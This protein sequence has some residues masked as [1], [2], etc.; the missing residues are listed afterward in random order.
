[1]TSRL[2]NRCF[3]ERILLFVSVSL[4]LVHA[5]MG[6]YAMN[7]DGVSYLDVGGAFFHG[8]WAQAVNAYWSPLYPWTIGILI[9]IVNPLPRW[10]FPLVHFVNFVVFLVAL[11][12]FRSFLEVL[13]T[14][15][16]DQIPH[17]MPSVRDPEADWPLLLLAYPVFWWA[18]LELV[19]LYD[20][21][22]DLM[23]M[24]CL[25]LAARILL[26]L[27]P[28]DTWWEFA[29]FGFVV[30]IGYWTKAIL[31][32]VGIVTLAASYLYRCKDKNWRRGIIVACL[33]FLLVS[34]PLIFLLSKQKGRF[35]FGDSGKLA[36]AWC[37][38]PRTFWRNWQGEGESGTPL[39]PTRQ[40]LRHPPIF[41][42]DGPVRG[43]YPPWTD[44]SYWN[45]GL[46]ARFEWEAQ[47]Q[48][49]ASNLLSEA[50][51][52]FRAQPALAVA[53]IVLALLSGRRWW[54][55]LRAFWPLILIAG[56]GLV[57]YLLILENDRYLGGFLLLF[58]IP[59][60]AAAQYQPGDQTIVGYLAIAAFTMM[61]L[62]TLDY[63]VRVATNHPANAGSG[64]NS[65]LQDLVAADQLLHLGMRSGDKIA[66]IGDGT[67]AYWARLAK[68]RI[69]AE[70][71]DMNH[72]SREFWDSP[73]DEKRNVYGVLAE[74]KAIAVVTICPA[75]LQELPDRWQHIDG[76][77]YCW[78][79][80][81]KGP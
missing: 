52:L 33:V 2:F 51:L 42:F 10:E 67:G 13:T 11:L 62:G 56:S 29:L 69:V 66:V 53:V 73:S 65:T 21:A 64:P 16:R 76:T 55:N 71:M 54:R 14:F 63:T 61:A 35:T 9:G 38:S 41:E 75:Y 28:S 20:V 6:R 79:S 27:R 81:I 58:F 25:L 17:S 8:D 46:R 1:M 34:T 39:H 18:A 50:R 40:L 68:L 48:V 5:W 23:V 45:D 22:P 32:P 78:R 70:I 74:T 44:P 37:V 57:A 15:H 49:L 47:A 59:L 31:F 36:Y 80:L 12:A 26:S 4:G 77:P 24:T 30:G 3:L 19:T 72:G 43:T 7:P 60:L